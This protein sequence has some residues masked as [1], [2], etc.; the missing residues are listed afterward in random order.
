[1]SVDV[2][3]GP[4]LTFVIFNPQKPRHELFCDLFLVVSIQLCALGYG[5]WSVWEARP[6]FLVAEIDR[7]KVIGRPALAEDALSRLR[8]IKPPSFFQGPITV[9]IRKPDNEEERKKILFESLLGGRDYGERPEF[10][11]PYEGNNALKS[12]DRAKPI[13]IFLNRYPDAAVAIDVL[14]EKT[15]NHKDALKYLPIVA[16]TS[17]VAILDV[18]GMIIGFVPGDGF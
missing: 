18:D 13:S 11:L 14:A 5:V 7:F 12:L 2:V 4:L 10:Y 8:N 16:R 6:L 15:K 17:W 9:A 3:T 1:M